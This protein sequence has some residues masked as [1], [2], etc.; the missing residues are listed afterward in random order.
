MKTISLDDPVFG[1]K[2]AIVQGSN[3]TKESSGASEIEAAFQGGSSEEWVD[4]DEEEK[5]DSDSAFLD[6][7]MDA[8]GAAFESEDDEEASIESTSSLNSNDNSGRVLD[9]N[10]SGGSSESEIAKAFEGSE[11]I[12][13]GNGLAEDLPDNDG[14]TA[15]A[16]SNPPKD[17]EAEQARAEEAPATIEEPKPIEAAP[18]EIKVAPEIK[19]SEPIPVVEWDEEAE[20]R[21]DER[22][23]FKQLKE[24]NLE[25][26][27]IE[28]EIEDAKE[29]LKILK[30][31]LKLASAVLL[32]IT[33]KGVEYRKKPKPIPV[34]ARYVPP[35]SELI[36]SAPPDNKMKEVQ[37]ASALAVAQSVSA[38]SEAIK[39]EDPKPVE[40][41]EAIETASILEGIEGL[42]K[43]KR[44]ALLDSF[45]NL[46]K[47][48]QAR[49]EASKENLPFAKLLPKG[50]GETIGTEIINRMDARIVP[51]M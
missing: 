10:Q 28:S 44:E 1:S 33:S 18:E 12:G 31:K 16:S 49:T 35:P 15:E 37:E 34:E 19:A 4:V 20:K 26:R 21:K 32:Q 2:E 43:K 48:M 9:G 22:T 25:V 11:A 29:N 45:P 27:V 17:G 40:N 42:G 24:A 46:G 5:I 23:F 6:D 3:E 50:I 39:P 7:A 41:W 13:S 47:L 51:G 36:S 38:P 14:G 8:I 30:S